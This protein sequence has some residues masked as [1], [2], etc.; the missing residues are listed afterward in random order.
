MHIIYPKIVDKKVVITNINHTLKLFIPPIFSLSVIIVNGN[1]VKHDILKHISLFIIFSSEE[2]FNTVELVPDS[3]IKL[4]HLLGNLL[5][6]FSIM[7][8]LNP[9]LPS[10]SVNVFIKS[11]LIILLEG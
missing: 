2:F 7:I 8:I 10:S 11:Y 9:K 6:L 1:I 3:D 5:N 4:L